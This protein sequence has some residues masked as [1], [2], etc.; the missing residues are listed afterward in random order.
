[1]LV[2]KLLPELKMRAMDDYREIRK[3]TT[4][5]DENLEENC[6]KIAVCKGFFDYLLGHN[7]ESGSD[8]PKY[9]FYAKP[10]TSYYEWY[11]EMDYTIED[12]LYESMNSFVMMTG[13][14]INDIV[15]NSSNYTKEEYSFAIKIF[16]NIEK[17]RSENKN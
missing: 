1:M 11:K 14:K 4:F 8:V 16:N 17:V 7:E 3:Q 13:A 5:S 6:L 12:E 2:K 10:I 9:L 15:A